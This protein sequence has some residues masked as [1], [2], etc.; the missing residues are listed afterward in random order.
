M[1]NL[2]TFGDSFTAGN[3]C[4]DRESYTK[5]YK[6]SEN[7]L[8]WPDKISK[9]LNYNLINCG[10]GLYSNDKILD[11]LIEKYNFINTNDLVVIGT[12]F[13]NRFDIPHNGTLITL[14]PTNAPEN[15][16]QILNEMILIMDNKLFKKRQLERILF[17]KYLFEKRGILCILWEV[18]T[19]WNKYESIRDASS[20]E[21]NDLHWSYKGH[22]DFVNYLLNRIKNNNIIEFI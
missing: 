9:T 5:E 6:K 11:T 15:N 13:Y 12:T 19:Q 18:E 17:F 14:S 20:G 8:I 22:N 21:I 7:D 10:M 2:W 1:N 4:L 16:N 3:G